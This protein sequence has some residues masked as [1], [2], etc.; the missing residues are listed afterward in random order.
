MGFKQ[1][2][3]CENMSLGTTRSDFIAVEDYISSGDFVS[4]A[5]M[6]SFNNVPEVFKFEKNSNSNFHLSDLSNVDQV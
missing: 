6:V 3:D 2:I 1:R 5:R 4:K